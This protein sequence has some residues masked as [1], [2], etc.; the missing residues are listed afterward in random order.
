MGLFSVDETVLKAIESLWSKSVAESSIIARVKALG[1]RMLR[2]FTDAIER[3]LYPDTEKEL[4]V[5]Y[6]LTDPSPSDKNYVDPL[7]D[8][9]T[10]P[11]TYYCDSFGRPVYLQL[12]GASG[13]VAASDYRDQFDETTEI[14]DD[15]HNSEVDGKPDSGHTPFNIL[16]RDSSSSMQEDRRFHNPPLQ[17]N[18]GP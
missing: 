1:K 13:L 12:D 14:D 10:S 5:E 4:V 3:T 7:K 16:R 11:V 18:K 15:T 9:E 8:W 2:S 17:D 6:G